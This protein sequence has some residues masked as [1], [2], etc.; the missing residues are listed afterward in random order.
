M[1]AG[2]TTGIVGYCGWPSLT[3]VER[4]LRAHLAK[5]IR[6]IGELDT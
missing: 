6:D 1:A 5:T 2:I 3:D 4:V